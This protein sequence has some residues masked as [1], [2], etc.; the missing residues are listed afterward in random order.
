MKSFSIYQFDKDA[1]GAAN[2]FK[3]V[4]RDPVS[5]WCMD[6]AEIDDHHYLMSDSQRSINLLKKPE[7]GSVKLV[8]QEKVFNVINYLYKNIVI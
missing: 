6:V 3:L 7:K 2:R 4:V 8:S 1:E 5:V